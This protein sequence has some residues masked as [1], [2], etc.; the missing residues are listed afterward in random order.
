MRKKTMKKIIIATAILLSASSAALAQ[1]AWTTG[2]ASDRERAGYPSPGGSS[3]YAYAPDYAARNAS[4]LSAFAS[5][6]QGPTGSIN[7][8]ALTGGGSTGYNQIEQTD[9]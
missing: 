9:R 1:S 7:D 8:P 6:P 2:T 3:I 4:G 5:V